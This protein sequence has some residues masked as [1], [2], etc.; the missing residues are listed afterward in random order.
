MARSLCGSSTAGALL[1]RLLVLLF[2]LC[3]LD[4]LQVCRLHVSSTVRSRC[5]HAL[6]RH[7]FV[8]CLLWSL[9]CRSFY[10]LGS[11]CFN[12]LEPA[13]ISL[14]GSLWCSGLRTYKCSRKGRNK[15][16]KY[17]LH[18]E[19]DNKVSQN[20][21]SLSFRLSLFASGQLQSSCQEVGKGRCASQT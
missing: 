4:V 14:S 5:C 11:R 13:I 1:Y 6:C 9:F 7:H 8:S 15:Q 19:K 3:F 20:G 12:F 17:K 18:W 2:L 10:L 16:D 21:R